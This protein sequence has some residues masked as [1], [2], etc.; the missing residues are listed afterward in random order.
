[1]SMH[2]APLPGR[3]WTGLALMIGAA[4]SYCSTFIM[5]GGTMNRIASGVGSSSPSSFDPSGM[6]YTMATFWTISAILGL[7]GL[8]LMIAGFIDYA[9][10]PRPWQSEPGY[11]EPR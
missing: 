11:A 1:M 2:S 7:L 3:V 10:R 4:L 9:R 6:F 8:V 5:M